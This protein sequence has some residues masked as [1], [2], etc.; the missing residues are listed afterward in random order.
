MR[1]YTNPTVTRAVALAVATSAANAARTL[2][3]PYQTVKRWRRDRAP[4]VRGPRQRERRAAVWPL[5]RDILAALRMHG[6]MRL[7]DL[8]WAIDSSDSQLVHVSRS[9]NRLVRRGL[10]ERHGTYRPFTYMIRER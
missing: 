2:D 7:R 1:Q 8:Y 3:I 4:I 9:V 5:Q 10:C 6:P